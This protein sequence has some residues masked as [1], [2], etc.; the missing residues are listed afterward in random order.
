MQSG[1][2]GSAAGFGELLDNGASRAENQSK[3][4][5]MD[6]QLAGREDWR[7]PE[8]N[9]KVLAAQSG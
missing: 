2:L 5:R 3:W 7:D 6:L 8:N 4:R 1:V 9:N